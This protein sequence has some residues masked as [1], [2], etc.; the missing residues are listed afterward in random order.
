MHDLPLA[1]STPVLL[2]RFFFVGPSG[3][4]FMAA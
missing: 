4:F 2:D 1:I 3:W